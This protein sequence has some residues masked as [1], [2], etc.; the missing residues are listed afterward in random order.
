MKESKNNEISGKRRAGRRDSGALPLGFSESEL[1]MPSPLYTNAR[2]PR[3]QNGAT[4]P[5]SRLR[6]HCTQFPWNTNVANRVPE[7]TPNFGDFP[8]FSAVFLLIF[9]KAIQKRCESG[10]FWRAVRR[11]HSRFNCPCRVCT[12]RRGKG[13]QI[14]KGGAN[15]SPL[16]R[17]R[18]LRHTILFSG[19]S[20]L[21]RLAL[22]IPSSPS[23]R[24]TA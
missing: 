15:D 16:P 10:G 19:L 17:T 12:H 2:T 21:C 7:N 20:R 18:P 1:F 11:R 4:G 22:H 13:H 6:K 14:P 5:V 9:A 8:A 23:L 24:D 3:T